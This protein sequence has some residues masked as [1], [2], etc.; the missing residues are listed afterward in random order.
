MLGHLVL[1]QPRVL[2]RKHKKTAPYGGR[3]F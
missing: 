2:V 3:F 1:L